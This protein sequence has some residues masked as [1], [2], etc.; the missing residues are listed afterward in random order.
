MKIKAV[1]EVLRSLA[2]EHLAEPWDHVGLQVGD[3][4]WSVRRAMLCIDLTHAVLQEAVEE[5]V[6]LIVAYHPLI[7]SPM[8]AVTSR[9]IKQQLVLEAARRK[10]A[11][12][13]PHTALD[14]AEA[15]VND[16][17]CSSLGAG[18]IRP[19]EPSSSHGQDK[20][21]LVTF[22][23]SEQAEDLRVTLADAGAGVIGDYTH[24]SFGV[25]GKGTFLGGASTQPTIGRSGRLESVPELR[26]E[27]ICRAARLS[28]VVTALVQAHP[29]EQPAF[30]LYRLEPAPRIGQG[31]GRVVTL[32][33]PTTPATLIKRL[34]QH[35]GVAQLNV[36]I[37]DGLKRIK[38]VGFCAGA[39]GSLLGKAGSID[40]F[41]TG[42]M[43]HHDVLWARSAGV[44][45]ILA[46]HTQ[47]ERPYLKVYRRR[48]VAAMKPSARS[49][50]WFVSKRDRP[51]LRLR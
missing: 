44:M 37:P 5:G 42:E 15:G 38:K 51:P 2:P 34:K 8:K 21:K 3:E 7:F 19:I 1:L 49:V 23:P 17:L 30:D 20:Y 11:V 40:A 22:V 27:M 45:V 10:I 48:I 13:S 28:A 43:R 31:Q 14:A 39:G 25:M 26:L 32:E 6:S 16:W 35:L 46:G 9:D 4:A 12:Y 50:T 29:Y 41:V 18:V 36:A 24:C 33:Q 47:S